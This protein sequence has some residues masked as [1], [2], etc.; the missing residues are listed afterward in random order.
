[1][2]FNHATVAFEAGRV[3]EALTWTRR[4]TR[5]ARDLGG[6]WSYYAAELRHLQVTALYM[7]G[8]WDG[9][10]AEADLLAR[11]PEMAAHVRADGLL[12]L[13]GR[14]DPAARERVDWARGLIPRL[15]AHILLDLVTAG[16]EIDLAAWNGDAQTA[17]DVALAAC[18]RLQQEWDDDHLGVLRLAGTALAPVAD[19]AAAARRDGNS[20][21]TDRWVAAG[22]ELVAI[23]RSAVE[24]YR[25]NYGDTMGVEA[26]AWQARVEAEAARVDGTAAPEPWRA[27]VEAFGFGHVYEQARSRWRLAEALLETGDRAGAGEQAKAAHEVAV[28][29]GAAP[30]R[31][32]LEGLIRRGRLDVAGVRTVDVSAVMTPREA[33]V[34]RLLAQGRTNRQI[35]AELYISE[36]TASVHVSNILGKLGANGRTEA[37]AIAAQRGLL[38]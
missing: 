2:L 9:S 1:M 30:L 35:G 3:D 26:R 25:R 13:V 33:E 36:K 4:G 28:R 34:L 21:T 31:T 17:L 32:A 29:L 24:V 15:R 23:A 12:V 8:D 5:R 20:G 11:V 14:G 37:V 38:A 6:D 19:A 27:A 7:T 22:A 18:R 16:S 10:L